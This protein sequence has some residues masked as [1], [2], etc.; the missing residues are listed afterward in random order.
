MTR[1]EVELLEKITH[2]T[3]GDVLQA[4]FIF[5]AMK[6]VINH[7]LNGG[8]TMTTSLDLLAELKKL[9][10]QVETGAIELTGLGLN[11]VTKDIPNIIGHNLTLLTHEWEYRIRFQEKPKVHQGPII[12]KEQCEAAMPWMKDEVRK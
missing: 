10:E 9:V 6:A 1:A 5:G 3:K 7:D 11:R 2:Q 8:K 12:T 4:A